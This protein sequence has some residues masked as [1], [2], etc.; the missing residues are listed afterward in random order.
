MS[1]FHEAPGRKKIHMPADRLERYS[2][3]RGDLSTGYPTPEL[4]RDRGGARQ[5]WHGTESAQE[6]LDCCQ[7]DQKKDLHHF[8][9]EPEVLLQAKMRSKQ[10]VSQVKGSLP[11]GR[12]KGFIVNL[13]ALTH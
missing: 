8:G 13:N 12:L 7:N 11:F 6:F 3:Y 5:T 2:E 9:S 10:S 4:G 1:F